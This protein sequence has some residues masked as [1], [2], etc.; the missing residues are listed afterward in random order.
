RTCRCP[1]AHTTEI[2]G[3]KARAA[4]FE[5]SVR[6]AAGREGSQLA[7]H[8]PHAN[9][10]G[11]TYPRSPWPSPP[12]PRASCRTRLAQVRT[13]WAGRPGPRCP[14]STRWATEALTKRLA[15]S[16]TSEIAGSISKRQR[17]Q[18]R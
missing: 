13:R 3:P 18:L 16:H 14:T 17:A 4:P 1:H 12:T 2:V 8:T 9:R 7:V 10:L 15:A 6:F 5:V 11:L